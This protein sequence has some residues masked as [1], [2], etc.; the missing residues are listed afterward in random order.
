MKVIRLDDSGTK[1]PSGKLL[2][3]TILFGQH[4]KPPV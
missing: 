2:N 4:K 3:R 1:T